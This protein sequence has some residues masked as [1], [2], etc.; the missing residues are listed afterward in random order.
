MKR[1]AFVAVCLFAAVTASAAYATNWDWIA[2]QVDPSQPD[3]ADE[4]AIDVAGVWPN[5]CLPVYSEIALYAGNEI[6]ADFYEDPFAY[7]LCW[8]V[9]TDFGSQVVATLPAGFYDVYAS[10]WTNMADFPFDDPVWVET[11]GPQYLMTFTVYI[12]GDID[13]DL[14]VNVFDI[15]VIAECWNA[16]SGDPAYNPDADLDDD[17]SIN[18]FDIF[19]IAENWNQSLQPP[20]LAGQA[21]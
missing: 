6:Y 3:A 11:Y 10:V 15:F 14:S 21:G 9:P 12:L 17:G 8:S 7:P 20:T 2:A 16:Q 1:F 18:V 4:I 13:R 5:D 19:V